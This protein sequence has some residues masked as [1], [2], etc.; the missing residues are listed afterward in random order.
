M[1]P[2]LVADDALGRAASVRLAMLPLVAL[3]SLRLGSSRRHKGA[4]PGASGRLLRDLYHDAKTRL[5]VH[6]AGGHVP[7][8]EPAS[9]GSQILPSLP[10]LRRQPIHLKQKKSGTKLIVA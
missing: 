6:E 9:V 4:A 10:R 1:S 3:L 8:E 7:H 2:P 5:R